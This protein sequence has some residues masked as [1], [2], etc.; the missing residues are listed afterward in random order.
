[1]IPK[2]LLTLSHVL[3]DM[4]QSIM[5]QIPVNQVPKGSGPRAYGNDNVSQPMSLMCEA[6]RADLN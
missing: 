2:V 1:M 4:T 6:R 5:K 3:T